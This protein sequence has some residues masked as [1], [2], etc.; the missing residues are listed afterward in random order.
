MFDDHAVGLPVELLAED[1]CLRLLATQ[2]V[3]RI[4][5]T[6]HALPAVLPVSFGL[7]EG[8]IV[9][10]TIPGSEMEAA[11]D[12]TIVAFETGEHDLDGRLG[13]SVLVVGRAS[14]IP[15]ELEDELAALGTGPRLLGGPSSHLVRLELS[16]VT[17]RR[18]RPSP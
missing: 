12:G 14:R 2:R 16:Q 7:V 8:G 5:F 10:G 4:A 15:G 13:W 17:G 1:E 11:T 6:V 3:G 18:F 9:L